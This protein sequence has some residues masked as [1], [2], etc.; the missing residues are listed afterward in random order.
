MCVGSSL[1]AYL[2]A[3]VIR[4]KLLHYAVHSF[5]VLEVFLYAY[6]QRFGLRNAFEC[7]GASGKWNGA[8]LLWLE[9][10]VGGLFGFGTRLLEWKQLMRHVTSVSPPCASF[11][12]SPAS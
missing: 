10:G 5:A 2:K 8:L 1:V 9:D 6:S 3:C 11:S 12:H 7:G 4:P